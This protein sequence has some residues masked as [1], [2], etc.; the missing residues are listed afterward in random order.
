MKNWGDPAIDA[1]VAL[2]P[3]CEAPA[4]FLAWIHVCTPVSKPDLAAGMLSLPSTPGRRG[5]IMSWG[6]REGNNVG[7]GMSSSWWH[8]SC[9]CKRC[10][11]LLLQSCMHCKRFSNDLNGA[12][13]VMADF[14]D[15]LSQQVRKSPLKSWTQKFFR[16]QTKPMPSI[17]HRDL[18][19]CAPIL[20]YFGIWL[21]CC[22]FFSNFKSRSNFWLCFFWLFVCL[23]FQPRK[24]ICW[25]FGDLLFGNDWS[26]FCA[27]KCA[28]YV[29]FFF[30]WSSP[31]FHLG[32]FETFLQTTGNA[33]V[34]W[35]VWTC[36]VLPC[37]WNMHSILNVLLGIAFW[38]YYWSGA[39]QSGSRFSSKEIKFFSE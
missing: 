23:V 4:C 6:T 26:S 1:I 30:D 22:C 20:T 18:W 34:L 31:F 14:A 25:L 32:L 27:Q 19:E 11:C 8:F 37:S 12:V 17:E 10:V 13:F 28:N 33:L 36:V 5:P 16:L 7:I 38:M 24:H 21:L 9:L 15:V 2:L 29:R 3:W 39:R 35:N